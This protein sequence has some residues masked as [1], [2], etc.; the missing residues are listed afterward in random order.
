MITREEL[1][2]KLK[3]GMKFQTDK[4]KFHQH[5]E[6]VLTLD[7]IEGFT[8]FWKNGRGAEIIEG[9]SKCYGYDFDGKNLITYHN[10]RT[11]GWVAV[12]SKII[13]IELVKKKKTEKK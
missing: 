5:D 2:L 7:K 9:L 4:N 3:A 11:E 10:D 6:G 12:E 13:Y 1:L 8:I